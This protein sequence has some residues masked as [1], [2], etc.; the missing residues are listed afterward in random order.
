MA[1]R[2]SRT[3]ARRVAFTTPASSLDPMRLERRSS[4]R[5]PAR[6]D[7]VATYRGADGRVGLTPVDLVDTSDGGVGVRS[8]V[9]IEPG[10]TVT[11]RD[12]RTRQPWSDAAC[13]R[14]TREGSGYRVGLRLNRRLA[15]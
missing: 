2:V 9:A 14:C 1:Y 4:V 15:A 12:A 13:V 5:L 11:L 7:L 8:P 6:G 3:A 10:M